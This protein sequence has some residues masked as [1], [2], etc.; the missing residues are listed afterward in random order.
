MLF[1]FSS[2][3]LKDW[4]DSPSTMLPVLR[5]LMSK[6][7]RVWL[8]RL[9]LQIVFPPHICQVTSFHVLHGDRQ[10]FLLGIQVTE[11]CMYVH[12]CIPHM[13]TIII[14]QFVMVPHSGDMD[15]RIPFL[16]TQ[17]SIGSLQL[18]TLIDWYPWY[19]NDQVCNLC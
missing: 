11:S 3:V 18:P 19:H 15:G 5:K 1:S 9:V 6:G 2:V 17:Y 7:L 13:Y 14:H 8:F 10:H 4:V 12:V 16:S